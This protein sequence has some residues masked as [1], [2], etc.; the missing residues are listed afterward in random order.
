M[1]LEDFKWLIDFSKR[2]GVYEVRLIG[3][4]PT[5]HPQFLEIIQELLFDDEITHIHIFSNGT[6]N[7]RILK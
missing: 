2:S 3:G 6:F 5:L 4:E 1:S 7:E